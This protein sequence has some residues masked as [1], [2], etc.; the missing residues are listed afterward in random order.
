MADPV[1]GSPS[2]SAS[3]KT[4][5]WIIIIIAILLIVYL[6]INWLWPSSKTTTTTTSAPVTVQQNLQMI[7]PVS[8]SAVNVPAGSTVVPPSGSAITAAAPIAGA[9]AKPAPSAPGTPS[10]AIATPLAQAATAV[11]PNAVIVPSNVNA[12]NMSADQLKE[13]VANTAITPEDIHKVLMSKVGAPAPTDIPPQHAFAPIETPPNDRYQYIPSR[14][15]YV[16][17]FRGSQFF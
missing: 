10:A 15:A 9:L 12:K 6:L 7:D 3:C 5:Q 8:G 13:H 1:V 14:N 16:P 17:P 11:K 2:E 4:I